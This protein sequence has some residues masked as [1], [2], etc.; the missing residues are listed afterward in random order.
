M[1]ELKEL[2]SNPVQLIFTIAML[3][4]VGEW[5][6]NK[7]KFIHA[8]ADDYYNKR[9]AD[10]EFHADANKT[11]QLVAEHSLMFEN[12]NTQLQKM[13]ERLDDI[14]KQ[15]DKDFV[16]SARTSLYQ[17]Y[18][19]L[20]DR[21]YLTMSEYEAF[22]KLAQRYLDKK[23]NGMYKNVIIPAILDKPVRDSYPNED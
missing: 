5:C 15:R 18:E 9:V 16:V 8:R 14:E 19:V 23:G 13:N 21:D 20:K 11:N 6:W 12:I 2:L 4:V 7:W 22:D 10:D 1:N 3:I 17:L